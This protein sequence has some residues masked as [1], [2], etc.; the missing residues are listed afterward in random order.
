MQH[1]TIMITPA[2]ML[3]PYGTNATS[4]ALALRNF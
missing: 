4:L 1:I 3:P 2:G